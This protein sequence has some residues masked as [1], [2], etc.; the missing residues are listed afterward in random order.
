MTV[1]EF[2]VHAFCLVF[3]ACVSLSANP[4]STRL[5]SIFFYLFTWTENLRSDVSAWFGSSRKNIWQVIIN[6]MSCG[7]L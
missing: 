3:Q 1:A 5:A 4:L 6:L 2:E 7:K